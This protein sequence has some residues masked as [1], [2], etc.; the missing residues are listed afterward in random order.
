MKNCTCGR[1]E[2]Y[3]LKKVEKVKK[4]KEE[5]KISNAHHFLFFFLQDKGQMFLVT[6]KILGKSTLLNR[7]VHFPVTT[8]FAL[9][10]IH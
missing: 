10:E 4:K 7:S 8:L 3:S 6:V 9:Q 1:F 2:E 5:K